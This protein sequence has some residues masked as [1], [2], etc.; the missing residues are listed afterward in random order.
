MMA[1]GS[2]GTCR[3]LEGAPKMTTML[4]KMEPEVDASGLSYNT[5]DQRSSRQSS[6]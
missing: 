5:P 1:T 2:T 3:G 6:P 4:A